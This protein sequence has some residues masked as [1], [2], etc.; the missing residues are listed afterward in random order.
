MTTTQ[1][2][3]RQPHPWPIFSAQLLDVEPDEPPEDPPDEPVDCLRERREPPSVS[4]NSPVLSLYRNA[5]R[6]LRTNVEID[7]HIV[8]RSH[9][10][11][12]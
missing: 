4:S 9:L 1:I 8:R 10:S 6:L 2:M 12:P 11:D 7:V 3:I 5:M